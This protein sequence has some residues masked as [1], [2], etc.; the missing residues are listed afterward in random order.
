VIDA[1]RVAPGSIPRLTERDPR[2]DLGLDSKDAAKQVR[3]DLGKRL[4][5]L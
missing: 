4:S 1:I 3:G 2:D 5:T